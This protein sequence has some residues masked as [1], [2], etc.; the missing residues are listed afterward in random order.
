MH[1]GILKG[2]HESGPRQGTRGNAD[3]Q[4]LAPALMEITF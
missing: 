1:K 4:N 2:Y 3:K